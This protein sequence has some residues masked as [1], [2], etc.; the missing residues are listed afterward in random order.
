MQVNLSSQINAEITAGL[1]YPKSMP[2][3]HINNL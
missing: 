3:F 2:G 1:T